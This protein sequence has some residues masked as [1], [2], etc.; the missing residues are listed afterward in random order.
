[1]SHIIGYKNVSCSEPKCAI[2]GTQ[3]ASCN[4]VFVPR[5][6]DC[7]GGWKVRTQI[8]KGDYGVVYQVCDES[9]NCEFV[10]KYIVGDSKTLHNEVMIQNEAAEAGLAPSILQVVDGVG[11]GAIIME[12]MTVTM[13]D[14][15]SNP[16]ITEAEATQ[17]MV[18]ACQILSGFFDLGYVHVDPHLGNIMQSRDGA[19]LLIDFGQARPNDN[20]AAMKADIKKLFRSYNNLVVVAPHLPDMFSLE[21]EFLETIG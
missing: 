8:G 17:A 9:D 5:S 4:R 11:D 13:Y 14:Y 19:W 15:L 2:D 3:V 6:K 21:D 10:Y 7:R 20:E 1:M 16:A 18:A 12:S